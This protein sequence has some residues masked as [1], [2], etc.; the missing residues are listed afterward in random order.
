MVAAKLEFLHAY[1]GKPAYRMSNSGQ[2]F[3]STG[4]YR[5]HEVII[6]DARATDEVFSIDVQGFQLL[7]APTVLENLE[8]RENIE[9]IYIPET[10]HILQRVMRPYWLKAIDFTVRTT[11]CSATHRKPAPRVHNDYTEN[12]AQRLFA[13]QF[14][15]Q[16]AHPLNGR[17]GIQLNVWRAFTEPVLRL[18]LALADA[19]SIDRHD[20]VA[21]DV[22]YPDRTGENYELLFRST[23]RWCYFRNMMR[24]EI[25]LIKGY[26]SLEDGCA[27]FTPH[28]AFKSLHTPLS[29]PDRW[30]IEVRVLLLM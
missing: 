28:S 4:E 18:P 2:S 13:D 1:S 17:R 5:R 10:L 29:A 21:C 20:L 23:Q 25:L 27:R 30:S 19:R 12:S 7:N 8:S 6:E 11:Q 24:D 22:I 14:G 26:D 16:N 9:K 3:T 15:I